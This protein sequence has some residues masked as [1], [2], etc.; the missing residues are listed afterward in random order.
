MAF[1]E[2]NGS[3]KEPESLSD[4][5]TPPSLHHGSMGVT[6]DA[7]I[8]EFYGSAVSES[9]RLKSELV[10]EHLLSIGMGK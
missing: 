9:Y 7:A 3:Q 4:V 1:D 8:R 6:D 5:P 10:S 2:K